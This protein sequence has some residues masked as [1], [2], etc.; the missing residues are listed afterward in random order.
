M[1]ESKAAQGNSL[2]VQTQ[3]IEG[4]KLPIFSLTALV[5][6]EFYDTKVSTKRRAGPLVQKDLQQS[7][8]VFVSLLRIH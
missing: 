2:N 1:R 7:M 4:R 8:L 6:G 3:F 5:L